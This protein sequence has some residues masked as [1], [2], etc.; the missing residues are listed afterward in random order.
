M[1][2]GSRVAGTGGVKVA[3]PISGEH[4]QL[5]PPGPPWYPL[6]V[7]EQ[8]GHQT[9]HGPITARGEIPA[10]I[11]NVQS[12]PQCHSPLY[13]MGVNTANH[14]RMP[15]NGIKNMD[16][17]EIS[18]ADLNSLCLAKHKCHRMCLN[19]LTD[20]LCISAKAESQRPNKAHQCELDQNTQ[21]MCMHTFCAVV[22]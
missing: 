8:P 22:Y 12:H 4:P 14:Q 5:N 7:Q 6:L 3:T 10:A 2:H 13:L 17:R 16:P 18:W 20:M 15:T 1:C 11:P 19:Y 9:C 21:H